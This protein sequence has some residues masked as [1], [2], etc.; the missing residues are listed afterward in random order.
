ME[1]DLHQLDLRYE[2]LRKRSPRLERQL[3]AS[4]A[5]VGQVLPIVVVEVEH[6]HFVV[7]D[8]YKRVR[9]LRRLARDRVQATVWAV[10][11]VEALLLE[12]LMRCAGEDALEQGWLLAELQERFTLSCDELA[13][14]F[15]KSKSW[16]SRRLALVKELPPEIQAQVRAGEL[17]AHAAM[18][19]LVPLARAN[20]KAA[21]ALVL[22]MAP[23]KPTTRQVGQ[24]CDGWRAGTSRTRELIVA[25]PQHFLRAQEE[26]QRELKAAEKSQLR[27]LLDD[28]G[29]LS[30]ISR[31]AQRRLEQGLLQRLLPGEPE[32]VTRV[33]AQARADAE[34]LFTRFDQESGHAR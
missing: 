9:A 21:T 34:K 19:H 16:V 30:G 32:E 15:D 17:A 25:T 6:R 8:G 10:Q 2:A 24:L 1:L 13:R 20:A 5:E 26:Q 22:A 31:R 18:K 12:R 3:V 29:A 28:L 33:S 14:R 23:L 4:L 27:Q 11:E 7:I